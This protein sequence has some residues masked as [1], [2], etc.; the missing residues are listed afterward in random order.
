MTRFLLIRHASTDAAGKRLSGRKPGVHLNEPGRDEAKQLAQRLSHVH[1]DAVY[2]SPLERAVQTA[3]EVCATI[4]VRCE[5]DE[6]FNEINFGDWTDKRIEE[7]R[8]DAL[9]Q[10]FN[11]FRSNTVIPG[12]ESMLQAQARI[13]GGLQNLGDKHRSKNVI[14]VS[15][16]DMIKAAIAYYAGMHIDFL[17]RIEI[18]PASVSIIDVFDDAAR[19][20]LIN[21]TGHVSF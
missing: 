12:G 5:I 4:N 6:S 14:V 15:H 21:H 9:F 13:V 18:S 7:L 10:Q 8:S 20:V 19:I 3:E 1:I 2:T 17:Q 11:S 16:S